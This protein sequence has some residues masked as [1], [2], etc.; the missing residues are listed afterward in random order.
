MRVFV[1]GAGFSKSM[2][3]I[4]IAAE[5]FEAVD[6][7]AQKHHPGYW[8]QALHFLSDLAPSFDPSNIN[9]ANIEDY[10]SLLDALIFVYKEFNE[11]NDESRAYNHKLHIIAQITEYLGELCIKEPGESLIA[12]ARMLKST[13]IIITFNWDILLENALY[14]IDKSFSCRPTDKDCIRII[15]LH[16]S[17]DWIDIPIEQRPGY[18]GPIPQDKT[19]FEEVLSEPPMIRARTYDYPGDPLTS[20]P[21][22]L[23]LPLGRPHF[24]V[25]PTFYKEQRISVLTTLWREAY[26]AVVKSTEIF[27][28][29]YAFPSADYHARAVLRSAIKFNEKEEPIVLNV[30]DIDINVDKRIEEMLGERVDFYQMD[31]KA[32]TGRQ[33]NAEL[34]GNESAHASERIENLSQEMTQTGH[35]MKKASM[36]LA[37]LC[38]VPILGAIYFGVIGFSVGVII[39]LF[40]VLFALWLK[41][42]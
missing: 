28:L 21:V 38:T 34:N 5:L 33:F 31:I 4:P 15:K 11:N 8:N 14:T 1:L 36:A 20:Y 2:A 37:F 10:L 32:F 41:R 24:I 25:P 30:V 19:L 40:S 29:G 17:I 23:M 39:G 13:D 26:R 12:F 22:D 6:D 3:D 27:F 18:T 42:K 16:G 9:G 35:R 7:H